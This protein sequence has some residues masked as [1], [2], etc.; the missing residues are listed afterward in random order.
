M[1]F[2]I[3]RIIGEKKRDF[4]DILLCYKNKLFTRYLSDPYIIILKVLGWYPLCIESNSDRSFYIHIQLFKWGLD[5]FFIYTGI[6]STCI[7][8]NIENLLKFPS[9]FEVM[10]CWNQNK[11]YFIWYK[12]F[13]VILENWINIKFFICVKTK[14]A[15][16]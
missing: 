10:I 9:L 7:Y 11:A 4:G 6:P 14:D 16:E 5:L 8:I 3:I 1:D 12:Y 15:N 13:H 2:Y